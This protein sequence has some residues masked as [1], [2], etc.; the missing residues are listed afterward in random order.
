VLT[1]SHKY[2]C[3]GYGIKNKNKFDKMILCDILMQSLNQNHRLSRWYAPRLQGDGT[4]SPIR[5]L[6]CLSLATTALQLQMQ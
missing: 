5:A 1:F 3:I 2:Q 4:G 6:S